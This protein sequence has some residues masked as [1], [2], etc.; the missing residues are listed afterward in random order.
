MDSAYGEILSPEHLVKD[1]YV[2]ISGRVRKSSQKLLLAG[3]LASDDMGSSQYA[4]CT[5]EI[6]Q[7]VWVIKIFYTIICDHR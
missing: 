2:E 5:R 3:V 6:C 1:M 4:E 7:L